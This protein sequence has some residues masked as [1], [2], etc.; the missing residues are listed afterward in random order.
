MITACAPVE[1][2]WSEPPHPHLRL[3]LYRNEVTTR[4][5]QIRRDPATRQWVAGDGHETID[6]FLASSLR[7]GGNRLRVRDLR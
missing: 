6:D 4:A 7:M 1:L 5:I 2:A 3:G